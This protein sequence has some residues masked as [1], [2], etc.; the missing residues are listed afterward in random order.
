MG[1]TKAKPVAEDSKGLICRDCRGIDCENVVEFGVDY[2]SGPFSGNSGR[3]KYTKGWKLSPAGYQGERNNE[4][5]TFLEGSDHH[6]LER[7]R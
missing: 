1:P 5:R 6:L 4:K 3:S 7:T 2:A